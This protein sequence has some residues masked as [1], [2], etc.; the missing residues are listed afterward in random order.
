M[1]SKLKTTCCVVGAG[2]AGVVLAHLLAMHGVD[3]ILL[4]SEDDFDRNFRGDTVHPSSME[5]LEQLGLAE[6]LLK[7]PHTKA[8]SIQFNGK[9]VV[10]FKHIPSKYKYITLLHQKD[11]LAF[12]AKQTK[13]Y[14][15]FKLMMGTNAQKLIKKGEKTIG[16][17]CLKDGKWIKIH[18]DLVV[19]ADGRFSR[20]RKEGGFKQ[21]SNA[22]PMDVLWFRMPK[23]P[24]KDKGLTS[25]ARLGKGHLFVMLEREDYWQIGFIIEK[26]TYGE[27][28][29][30][31][32]KAFQKDVVSLAPF[33]KERIKAIKD[34]KGTVSLLTVE[35]TMVK[36]WYR[37]GLLLIGDAA[38]VMSPVGGVGINYA[39]KDAVTAANILW[40][41][42]KEKRL[43]TKHLAKIQ[44][45]RKWP[46]R[47]IQWFQHRA[48]N[49]VLDPTLHFEKPPL[50]IRTL[51]KIPAVRRF[52][53]RIISLG[54]KR[55]YVKF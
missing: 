43:Q 52:M 41:P 11:F 49:Q 51:G 28:R 9:K 4:E 32:I 48:Q 5:I 21:T 20:M 40:K 12:I 26:E 7:L 47:L 36:Q 17:E 30:E 24:K 22:T 53:A 16:V 13:K 34:W 55:V 2:P 31:G 46:T 39:I 50:W 29:E 38:H 27:M 35:S 19:G 3:T 33:L 8:E 37:D 6:K 1:N 10:D 14:K 23:D 42:L 54:F 45:A 44:K 18:A 15:N 25:G